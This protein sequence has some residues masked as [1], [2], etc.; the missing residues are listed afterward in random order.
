MAYEL[1]IHAGVSG[2]QQADALVGTTDKLSGSTSKLNDALY[3]Q[4]KASE[5]ASLKLVQL[6]IEEAKLEQL[7]ERHRMQIEGLAASQTKSTVVNEQFNASLGRTTGSAMAATAALRELE[8]AS[9]MRAAGR[10]LAGLP[11]LG[12]ALQFAF[13]LVGA[14]ALFEVLSKVG[15]K[16]GIHLNFWK[17]IA[18]AQKESNKLLEDAT[19]TYEQNIKK[20]KE[21]RDEEY[22]AKYGP[23]AAAR[24]QAGELGQDKAAADRQVQ[25]LQREID[26]IR[27]ITGPATGGSAWGMGLDPSGKFLRQGFTQF[28]VPTQQEAGDLSGVFDFGL[29]PGAMVPSSE[30]KIM[31]A[32]I[33]ALLRQQLA[34]R[35]SA[36]VSTATANAKLAQAAAR[37]SF[38]ET[39]SIAEL[40]KRSREMF[41]AAIYGGEDSPQRHL[42]VAMAKIEEERKD[43]LR[44]DEERA[45]KTH[46]AAQPRAINE[47]FDLQK[48]AAF[49]KF[50]TESSSALEKFNHELIDG[51]ERINREL[52]GAGDA[53]EQHKRW[54]S[55]MISH[56]EG[57]LDSRGNLNPA[58]FGFG[59]F[60]VEGPARTMSSPEEQLRDA[61][62]TG[63]INLRRAARATPGELAD[64]ATGAA[65]RSFQVRMDN[66]EREYQAELR[67]ANLKH[68]EGERAQARQDALDQ[69]N[70]KIFEAQ[71][72]REDVIL[73]LIDA[74]IN[75]V[76]GVGANLITAAQHGKAGSFVRSQ[77]EG[78][79]ST[80]IQNVLKMAIGSGTGQSVLGSLHLPGGLG[81]IFSGTPF[82]ADPTK[83]ATQDNTAATNANTAATMGLT[84]AMSMSR[85]GGGGAAVPMFGAGDPG[86]GNFFGPPDVFGLDP[87]MQNGDLPLTHTSSIYNMNLTPG[88]S[89]A[90]SPTAGKLT[91]TQVVGMAA[92][93]GAA[94]YGA[95]SGFKAGGAQGALMG[96]SSILGAASMI[97]GPQQPF[98]AAAA[99]ITGTI[100]AIMGDPKA[101]REAEI[102]RHLKYSQFMA[103]IAISESMSTSGTFSDFDRFGGVRSSNLSAMPQVAQ[104]YFDYRHNQVVPGYVT[105][106]FGG[107]SP[108]QASAGHPQ[109][110][111]NNIYAMDGN[112]VERVLTR[113]P[114]AVG[115]AMNHA[116]VLGHATEFQ[117][118]MRSQ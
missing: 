94:A 44:K 96:T 34:L 51:A 50:L 62:R 23:E 40:Q 12:A 84:R 41:G 102:T 64:G 75:R 105:S 27:R 108:N 36:M 53:V 87:M 25:R 81:K 63:S 28:P 16:L 70:E 32:R 91:A 52:L 114:A 38:S 110:V 5:A 39:D 86:G 100:A 13:P 4:A 83:I 72:D 42:S 73:S 11:T 66:A 55:G 116:V 8:G 74:Q 106:P 88:G 68:D 35:S 58:F 24:R 109:A 112:D 48:T 71:M 98:V 79:E 65:M 14:I 22:R 59:A 33:P 57:V 97:P 95:Y 10:F 31:Q 69:K 82:G 37:T 92:A 29:A 6:Q 61:R 20:L 9:S 93:A 49:L 45:L 67:I 21:L 104:G 26:A 77:F 54:L 3:G 46:V 30:Q 17:Q 76:A 115:K 56:G 85:S 47:A 99:A 2:Q 80:V 19:K 101:N 15:D 117:T 60:D 18:D 107:P 1:N 78:L 111:V 118:T 43:T 89:V 7:R 113:H 90:Y 103:P